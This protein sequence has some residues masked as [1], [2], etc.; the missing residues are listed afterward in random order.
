MSSIDDMT[1]PTPLAGS[2][3]A[4]KAAK[5]AAQRGTPSGAHRQPVRMKR[6]RPSN[7][8]VLGSVLLFWVSIGIAAASLWPIYQTAHFVI[9]VVV[10]VLIGTVIALLGAR[11]R[12]PSWA[13][14]VAGFVAFVASGVPLA[15]P[16][17]AI[18]GVLPSVEGLIELI[19]GVALG[20]KQLLTITLPVGA[21]QALLVPA[22]LLVLGTTISGLSVALRAKWGELG[23]IPPVALFVVGIVFGPDRSGSPVWLALALLVVTLIT[24]V[25]R[26]WRRR[27][28]AI[29]S[30]ARST[31][32]AA[33]NP[34]ATALDGGLVGR[35]ILAGVVILALA[36]G[37][38]VVTTA[39]LPPTSDRTVLRTAVVQPFDPRDYASPLS[40][41]RRYLLNDKA[42]QVQFRISGLPA[43]ARIRIATLD[44]YDGVVYAVGSSAV[45]S[46]SGT[47]VRIPS[48][49]DQSGVRGTQLSLTVRLEGYS[50]VWLPTV[51]DF[52]SVNFSGNNAAQLGDAFYYNNVSGTAAVL[53]GVATGDSY[54]IDT[55]LPIQ[56]DAK[57]LASL[58]PGS[59]IL[60]HIGVLPDDLA[61][62]LDSYVAGLTSPGAR[63]SAMLDGLKQE[64]Y[65]SHGIDPAQPASRS[66]H[67]ADR[68][69]ELFTDP[70]MIGDAEQYS[71]AAALMARQLGFPARVV[72]GFA[73]QASTSTID[74][75]GADVSA[76]IE[77]DTA[78]YGWV[79]IDPNPQVRPIPAEQPQDPTKV[80]RPESIVPPPADKTQTNE[81]Q[82]TP[83][84]S[85]NSPD[86]LDPVLVIVLQVLKISAVVL[87]V[88]LILA[89]PFLLIVAAKLRRRRIRN[90]APSALQRI[91]GGWEEFQDAVVDHGLEPPPAAT[92]SEV[93][94]VVGTLPSRVL[95]AV[96]DRAVFAPDK[97]DPAD[98]DRVWDAVAEL[99]AS[100]DAPLT[101]RRRILA[102]ISLRS[103]GGYSGRGLFRRPGRRKGR[104]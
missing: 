12:W 36:G 38:A 3:G 48:A 73:P 64:G 87:L 45:D 61:Q 7:A 62:H 96:A 55:V 17:Q 60:P 1:S 6:Q 71:V 4:A 79:T 18:S 37:A 53:G 83:D 54:S 80:A 51:G 72:F 40:G 103:L 49:V 19:S 76:W 2:A 9:L 57:Q 29:R 27:R 68:I 26:R 28:E 77:V 89:A 85:Q 23:V 52:E 13:V 92:R 75:T 21:Y 35:G 22:L 20:W 58:S 94:G 25:W 5:K 91:R 93:A 30:L 10:A 34:L 50:G 44:S 11:F 63:L 82:T 70:R 33:G 46:A 78:Q 86:A 32:D 81:S 8:L 56:P 15:V 31:P 47:F 97:V 24:L 65:I 16:D 100:L 88:L 14:V 90:R 39:V 41:F 59:A 98:A 95:A 84:T 66:G 69:S 42:S 74:V 43:G 101:R 67:A 99:R 102:M 104:P